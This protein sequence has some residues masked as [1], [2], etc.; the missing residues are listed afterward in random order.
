MTCV[1]EDRI[2]NV[3]RKLENVENILSKMNSKLDRLVGTSS[4][5][6]QHLW[7]PSGDRLTEDHQMSVINQGIVMEGRS[8]VSS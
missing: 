2:T 6:N 4:D 3:E 1:N 7:N 5:D 8:L